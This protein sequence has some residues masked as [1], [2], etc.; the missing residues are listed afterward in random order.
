[1]KEIP[2]TQGKVALVDDE[3]FEWLNQWKWTAYIPRS[4]HTV[5]AYRHIHDGHAYKRS[6]RMHR[7][8]MGVEDDP[9]RNVDHI[10]HNGLDN[11]RSN[12]RFATQ[13]QN[14]QNARK[15][16]SGVCSFKGVRKRPKRNWQAYITLEGRFVT[17][18]S[19]PTAEQAARAY[20]AAARKHFGSFACCNFEEVD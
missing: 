14:L 5:Y 10:N 3:D 8:I 15:R 19:F 13:Q 4:G 16:R 9:S 17:L 7:L 12:L 11:R 6:I 20:D 2:L 18:G 1:M